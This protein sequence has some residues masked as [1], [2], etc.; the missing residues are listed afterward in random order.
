[1]DHNRVAVIDDVQRRRLVIELNWRQVGLLRVA[2]VN[3]RLLMPIFARSKLRFE[4]TPMAGSFCFAVVPGMFRM[5]FLG[6]IDGRQNKAAGNEHRKKTA[7]NLRMGSQS[8]SDFPAALLPALQQI[9]DYLAALMSH[10]V[11]QITG[12]FEAVRVIS[13]CKMG[14]R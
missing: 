3:G 11:E 5:R 13:C 1:I 10:L 9:F 7:L 2:N 4:F 14:S 6:S 8:I 12:G